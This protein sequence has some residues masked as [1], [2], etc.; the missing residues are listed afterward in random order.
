M[1]K[2]VR[3]YESLEAMKA[4]EYRQWQKRT[5]RERLE[6]AAELS[7]AALPAADRSAAG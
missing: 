3:K 2:T 5:P 6:A 1:D 7:L 4:D